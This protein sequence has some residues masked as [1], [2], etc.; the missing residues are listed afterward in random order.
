MK[1]WGTEELESTYGPTKVYVTD[2]DHAS[3]LRV[4]STITMP[5]ACEW[6]FK[7]KYMVPPGAKVCV[8]PG[9]MLTSVAPMGPPDM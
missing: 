5:V 4:A 3:P 9:E 7:V 2:P 8:G 6:K 1:L